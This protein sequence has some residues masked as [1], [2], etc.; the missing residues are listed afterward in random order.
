MRN[1]N[2]AN[3]LL[4]V[5]LTVADGAGETHDKCLFNNDHEGIGIVQ[6]C[7]LQNATEIKIDNLGS[8]KLF[9][10]LKKGVMSQL[11]GIETC[12]DLNSKLPLPTTF[13]EY[14]EFYKVLSPN[15]ERHWIDLRDPG[16]TGIKSNWKDSEGN[17]PKFVKLR[18]LTYIFA[19][20]NY[21]LKY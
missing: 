9:C 21:F 12:K 16:Q 20:C 19:S 18:V 2:P 4:T 15:N 1:L 17:T 11:K 10:V 6:K 5:I 14:D 13:G 3:L 7:T 8:P